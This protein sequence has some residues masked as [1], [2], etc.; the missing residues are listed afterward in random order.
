MPPRI[1]HDE[2]VLTKTVRELE[3][4][5]EIT[6]AQWHDRARSDFERT[7]LADLIP[8]IRDAADAIAQISR[9]LQKAVRECS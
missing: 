6:G 4:H 1:I 3:T 8:E 7:F 2:A 5:W 9:L